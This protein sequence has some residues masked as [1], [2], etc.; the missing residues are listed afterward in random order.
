MASHKSACSQGI[1][2]FLALQ[3]IPGFNHFPVFRGGPDLTRFS[4]CS[5]RFQ[6]LPAAASNRF[7]SCSF[8]LQILPAAA[9]A[10]SG[11]SRSG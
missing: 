2:F 9:S 7:S 1:I 6:I 4:P 5:F 11:S 10:R 3:D 8:R